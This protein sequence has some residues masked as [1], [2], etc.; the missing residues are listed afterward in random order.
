MTD[1][2]HPP[3][4]DVALMDELR[5][6]LA[7]HNALTLAYVDEAGVGA[8]GLWYAADENF[9]CYFLSSP[10]TRHGRALA[11]G[12]RVA[13]TIH[14]DEQDWQAIRGVQGEGWCSP[15]PAADAA[16]PWRLY[17]QRFP[18]VAQQFP[19][20]DAAL[21]KAWLWHIEPS[22]LRL[23]DNARGFGHKREIML[24]AR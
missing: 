22:W 24:Q 21:R 2:L 10:T 5:C 8:C 15:V 13:F 6:C 7:Q 12:G 16:E 1:A 14:K 20:L 4:N 23:I 3:A 9:V 17:V 11:R 18:F 19:D